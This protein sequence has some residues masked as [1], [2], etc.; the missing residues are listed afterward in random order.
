MQHVGEVLLK[1]LQDQHVKDKDQLERDRLAEL[2]RMKLQ[3]IAS[4]QAEVNEMQRKID[5]QLQKETD[6]LDKRMRAKK[7]EILGEKKRSM[8]DRMRAMRGNLTEF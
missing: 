7:D 3:L 4:N 1:A 2:E 8:E 6:E 5:E